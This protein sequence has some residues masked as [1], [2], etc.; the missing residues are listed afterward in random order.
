[1]WQAEA[2][3]VRQL[4]AHLDRWVDAYMVCLVQGREVQEHGARRMCAGDHSQDGRATRT[5]PMRQLKHVRFG[6]CFDWACRK[7]CAANWFVVHLD[8][9]SLTRRNAVNIPDNS[10]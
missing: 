1:M 7:R 5:K 8:A 4:E 10:T 2:V 6:G 9:S 3:D